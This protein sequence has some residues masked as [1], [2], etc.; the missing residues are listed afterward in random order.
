MY[1]VLCFPVYTD[2]VLSEWNTES[3]LSYTEQAI[4]SLCLPEFDSLDED[5]ETWADACGDVWAYV[6]A[7]VEDEGNNAP[8]YSRYVTM[9]TCIATAE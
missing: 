9:A 1:I 8:L 6:T 5:S 7:V 2:D 3:Q 4:L